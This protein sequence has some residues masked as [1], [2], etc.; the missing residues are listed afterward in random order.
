[1]ESSSGKQVAAASGLTCR[2]RGDDVGG[3]PA[4]V[5]AAG[6]GV[7]EACRGRRDDRCATGIET[8]DLGGTALELL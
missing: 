1:M 3:Q 7:T 8:G 5:Q 2:K 6:G 4:Q